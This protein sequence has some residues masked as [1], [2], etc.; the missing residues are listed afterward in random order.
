MQGL[1]EWDIF[2]SKFRG[3]PVAGQVPYDSCAMTVVPIY[4][5]HGAL[6]HSLAMLPA[7]GKTG[8]VVKSRSHQNHA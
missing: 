2:D 7:A 8:R 1:L 5:G 4:P 6:N 3:L